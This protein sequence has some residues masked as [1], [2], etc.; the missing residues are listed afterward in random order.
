MNPVPRPPHTVTEDFGDM[1]VIRF[2]TKRLYD[3]STIQAV[4]HELFRQPDELGRIN[5][6]VD[7]SAVTQV[8]SAILGKFIT[9][10][11]KVHLAHGKLMFC[12]VPSQLLEFFQITKLDKIFAL[13]PRP[14]FE[15]AAQVVGSSSAN[16]CAR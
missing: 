12:C 5:L 6:V 2:V 15:T 7:C 3:S 13:A 1:T 10:A 11:R 16:W 9:L 4:G 8:S 14:P